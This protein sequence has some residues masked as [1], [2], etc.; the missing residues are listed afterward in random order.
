MFDGAT[1]PLRTLASLRLH[2]TAAP[3]YIRPQER[4]NAAALC[5]TDFLSFCRDFFLASRDWFALMSR[6]ITVAFCGVAEPIIE[7]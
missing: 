4:V 1:Q 6:L 7:S 3:C 2:F 5:E